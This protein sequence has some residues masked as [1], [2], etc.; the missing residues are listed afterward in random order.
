MIYV[1]PRLIRRARNLA[2]SIRFAPLLTRSYASFRMNR[3][4]RLKC[5]HVRVVRL[6]DDLAGVSSDRRFF[7]E[8]HAQGDRTA[9]HRLDLHFDKWQ[10][11]SDRFDLQPAASS[12]AH[13]QKL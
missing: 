4:R 9:F 1:S 8:P 5:F 13:P 11:G 3:D 12:R 2:A 6:D 7:A 10:V